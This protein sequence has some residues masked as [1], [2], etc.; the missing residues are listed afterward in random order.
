MNSAASPFGG[1]CTPAD[2]RLFFGP[3]GETARQ[4]QERT[5]EARRICRYC[6]LRAA[7]LEFAVRNHIHDGIWGGVDLERHGKRMCRNGLH[8]M[9]AANTWTDPDGHRNCRACRN[10]ADRR[11]RARQ[12]EERAA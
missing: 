1:A 2:S 8:L 10:A 7:C 3:D 5:A 9:D 11:T 12:Q 4:R 6:P